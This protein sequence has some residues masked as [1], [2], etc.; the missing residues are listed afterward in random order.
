MITENEVN[1]DLA[2]L[3]ERCIKNGVPS[4][5]KFLWNSRPTIEGRV[6][7]D[8]CEV[9]RKELVKGTIF[10]N[11]YRTLKLEDVSQ[12]LLGKG[13]HGSG[14][15][16]GANVHTLT[17]EQQKQYV[18]QDAQ[19]G[20][21]LSKV[22]NGQII[23]LMQAIAE[24]TGLSL[25]QVCHSSL[26]TWW[27][28][29]FDDMGCVPLQFSGRDEVRNQQPTKYQGALVIEPKPGRY[30]NL[31][32]VDVVSLY[33][34]VAILHNISFDSVN[35]ACCINREDAKISAD[36]IDKGYWICKQRE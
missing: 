7:I 21:D 23:S 16:S 31:K 28:K 11:K 17:V 10:R 9:F 8:L 12:A 36:V 33:P 18:L 30:R 4:P 35:C 19:L 5:V 22:N 13:K 34:S 29:V 26:S 32:V 15:I 14:V 27:T 1:S 24:L 6:H 3:N 2:V 20:M 25:E